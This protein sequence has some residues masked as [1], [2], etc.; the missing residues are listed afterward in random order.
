MCFNTPLAALQGWMGTGGMT[1]RLGTGMTWQGRARAARLDP[2][3]TETAAM[4]TLPRAAC[5]PGAFDPPL[6]GSRAEAQTGS[7]HPQRAS[8]SATPTGKNACANG[9]N[10]TSRKG[11]RSSN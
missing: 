7:I 1:S 2:K 4:E 11:R 3:Q 6:R 10:V 9:T 5:K 8:R